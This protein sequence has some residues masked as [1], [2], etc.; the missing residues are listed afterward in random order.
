MT[1]SKS[2]SFSVLTFMNH[3]KTDIFGMVFLMRA[4][5]ITGLNSHSYNLDDL[6]SKVELFFMLIIC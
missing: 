5:G 1:Q 6:E 2:I 3:V 4:I